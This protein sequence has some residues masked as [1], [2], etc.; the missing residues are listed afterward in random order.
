[1]KKPNAPS[2]YVTFD[3]DLKFHERAP[4]SKNSNT[5]NVPNLGKT[6]KIIED[7]VLMLPFESGFGDTAYDKSIYENNALLVN[8]QWIT[9]GTNKAIVISE[10]NS[11][12]RV[13]SNPVLN[14]THGIK[15]AAK[16]YMF[17]SLLRQDRIVI[18]KHDVTGGYTLGV[19]QDGRPFF[20]IR[21]NLQTTEVISDSILQNN[22]WY[23]IRA[24]FSPNPAVLSVYEKTDTTGV[25][26]YLPVTYNPLLIG[27]ENNLAGSHINNFN[28]LIDS[29]SIRTTVEYEDFDFIRVAIIDGNQLINKD[30]LRT[31]DVANIGEFFYRFDFWRHYRSD[32]DSVL[33]GHIGD[34][35]PTWTGLR[36]VW[37]EYFKVLSEQNLI[38]KGGYAEGTLN[39]VVGLNLLTVAALRN[40]YVLYY[41]EGF[42]LGV[43]D[44]NTKAH[45]DLY[46]PEY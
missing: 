8:V 28:G 3:L 19:G 33:Y 5:V 42:V 7:Q 46:S 40:G 6:N 43:K 31:I 44:I 34:K 36:G 22:K 23:T 38:L 30:S 16:V 24:G 4:Q 2:G 18:D 11:Y 41:G 14:G 20:R 25:T 12:A 45:I 37:D 32:L 13:N 26:G 10:S 29:V 17:E 21:Q 35:P 9:F 15:M 1:M 39:G 27:A